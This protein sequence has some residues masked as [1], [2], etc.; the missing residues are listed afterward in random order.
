[1]PMIPGNRH[2]EL[3]GT[4]E[5]TVVTGPPSGVK[6]LVRK[7]SF[8]NL[9]TAAV[10]IALGL[11]QAGSVTVLDRVTLQAGEPGIWREGEVLDTTGKSLVAVLSGAP[12][13]AQPTYSSSF[14]DR[15]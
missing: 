11:K 6:R 4:T 2:G 10:T 3:N 5:V 1:M 15:I 13:T 12:S 14:A 9:D 7:V 8:H